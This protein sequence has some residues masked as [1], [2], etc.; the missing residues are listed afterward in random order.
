MKEL[1]SRT[2]PARAVEFLQVSFLCF[3]LSNKSTGKAIVP[4]CARGLI[5][6]QIES[7]KLFFLFLVLCLC[8]IRSRNSI[9]KN[10]LKLHSVEIAQIDEV[11]RAS[12][13]FYRLRMISL[14]FK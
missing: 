5:Y 9:E 8:N 12:C 13:L 1:I 14:I 10:E 3:I 6:L 7:H 11:N 2:K 4:L